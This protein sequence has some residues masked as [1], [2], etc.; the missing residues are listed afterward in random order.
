MQSR[1]ITARANVP[2]VDTTKTIEV[3]RPCGNEGVAIDE[4]YWIAKVSAVRYW[5]DVNAIGTPTES[6]TDV[7]L[8]RAPLLGTRKIVVFPGLSGWP[9]M[10]SRTVLI[11]LLRS[12]DARPDI[13]VGSLRAAVILAA[14]SL[15]EGVRAPE[16][17]R[18]I[19]T[20]VDATRRL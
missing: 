4:D 8:S 18:A 3:S 15:Y 13:N 5:T 9:S 1:E 17:D 16:T 14:H 7:R 20:L 11:D 19:D 6:F 10:P 12:T 2:L